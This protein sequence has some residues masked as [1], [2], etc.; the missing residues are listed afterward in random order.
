MSY[1][2]IRYLSII[3]SL[4][5]TFIWI[6]FYIYAGK[7]ENDKENGIKNENDSKSRNKKKRQL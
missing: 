1:S 2:A 4:L 6:V 5:Y 3:L 7:F